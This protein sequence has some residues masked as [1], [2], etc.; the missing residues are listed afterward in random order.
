M[1]A[2][3]QYRPGPGWMPLVVFLGL[4]LVAVVVFISALANVRM[5]GPVLTGFGVFTSAM[6]F[7]T[8][9]IGLCGLLAIAPNEARVL[10]LFGDYKGTIVESGFFWVNP[11]YSKKRISLRIRNF[12]NRFE[13]QSGTQRC[14]WADRRTQ[15]ENARPTFQS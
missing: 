3:K 15:I 13:E 12:R 8:G 6:M 2:E 9:I 4:M 1:H 11:F 14:C 10:L 7:L 5:I